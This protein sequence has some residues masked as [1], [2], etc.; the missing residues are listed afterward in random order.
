MSGLSI[1]LVVSIPGLPQDAGLPWVMTAVIGGA[2]VTELLLREHGEPAAAPLAPLGTEPSAPIDELEDPGSGGV[3]GP[4]YREES[5][6]HRLAP[7]PAT[8]PPRRPPR[9][10]K[11]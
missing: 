6:P 4:I 2:I 1:A 8:T 7:R 9:R 3:E 11:P 10:G 5:G